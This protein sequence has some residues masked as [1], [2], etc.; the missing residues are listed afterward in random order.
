M[1]TAVLP[2]ALPRLATLAC[3]WKLWES[4]PTQTLPQ[5]GARPVKRLVALAPVGRR[6]LDRRAQPC[7][8]GSAPH[9]RCLRHTLLRQTRLGDPRS[10]GRPHIKEIEGRFGEKGLTMPSSSNGLMIAPYALGWKRRRRPSA[11]QAECLGP[12]EVRQIAV[13]QLHFATHREA[14]NPRRRP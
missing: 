7:R 10:V 12:D 14:S 4:L 8:E 11:L 6:H 1:P 13:L 9:P 5:L 2:A 3:G